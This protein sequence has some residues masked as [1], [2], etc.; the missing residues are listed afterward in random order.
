MEYFNLQALRRQHPAWRLLA[1][2]YAPLIVSF[3]HRTFIHPNIRT[4]A[5]QDLISRL[6][7]HLFYLREQLG[8]DFFPKPAARYLDDWSSDEHGWLRKY[9]MRWLNDCHQA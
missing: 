5:Q 2:E 4:F 7:D 8:E 1:A 6:Q 3:L 9:W